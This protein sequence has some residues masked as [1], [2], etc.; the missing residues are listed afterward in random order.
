MSTYKKAAFWSTELVM[1][2]PLPK[3]AWYFAVDN[4]GETFAR[5]LFDALRITRG[6]VQDEDRRWTLGVNL[7][8]WDSH[9][10]HDDGIGFIIEQEGWSEA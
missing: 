9:P 6:V 5:Q 3:L 4:D 2:H 7:V 1:P 10:S 8:L